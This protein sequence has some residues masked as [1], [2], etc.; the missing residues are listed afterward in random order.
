MKKLIAVALF[1]LPLSNVMAAPNEGLGFRGNS[2]GG[3][4]LFNI[5]TDGTMSVSTT[6]GPRGHRGGGRAR[7]VLFIEGNMDNLA[8]DISRSGGE[9]LST[10][11]AVWGVPVEDETAFN[12]LVQANFSEVFTSENVTSEEVLDNLNHIVSTDVHL[13]VYTLS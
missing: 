4:Q 8:R 2:H 7:L 5:T 3:F 12:E 9:T 1:V 13:A 11:T 10:L 6:S